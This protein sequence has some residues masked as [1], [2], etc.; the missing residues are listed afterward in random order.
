[1]SN[2]VMIA[3]QIVVDRLSDEEVMAQRLGLLLG[4]NPIG[5]LGYDKVEHLYTEQQGTKMHE[6]TKRAFLAITGI[7]E[8]A[9]RKAQR[10][11]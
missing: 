1:M 8:D 3:V 9:I 10:E 7:R 6:E 5:T 2:Y 4:N 11:A